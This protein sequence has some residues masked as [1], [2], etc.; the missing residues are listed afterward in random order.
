VT[1]HYIHHVPGRLR[2]RTAVVK[3]NERQA[4]AVKALLQSTEGVRTVAV[5]PLTG[6]VTVHY[7]EKTTNPSALMDVLNRQGYPLGQ[8]SLSAV[9]Q[10]SPAA[11]TNSQLGRALAATAA[12]FLVK[13]AVEYS[14]RALVASLL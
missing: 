7:D 6:S 12:T 11:S 2:V 3:R 4:T 10:A 8:T 13:T 1:D 5:N 9:A 14:L